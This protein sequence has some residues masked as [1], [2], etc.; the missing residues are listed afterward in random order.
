VDSGGV[1]RIGD[2]GCNA[3][4]R[5]ARPAAG[6][7]ALCR[8]SG[9]VYE[10]SLLQLGSEA[11]LGSVGLR[12][13]EYVDAAPTDEQSQRSSRIWATSCLAR[14]SNWQGIK[15]RHS[16]E[17]QSPNR[18]ADLMVPRP[19]RYH[20]IYSIGW[21]KSCSLCGSCGSSFGLTSGAI[22][23]SRIFRRLPVGGHDMVVSI[24]AS[25]GQ[26]GTTGRSHR[27]GMD[28]K[29]PSLRQASTCLFAGSKEMKL[30]KRHNQK[31]MANY[32]TFFVCSPRN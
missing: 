6:P 11:V 27:P 31:H 4:G 8:H 23:Q 16:E 19:H 32:S 21:M 25:A 10:R 14:M 15:W 13:E 20:R 24:T 26:R 1:R 28:Y 12:H 3:L 5:V 29:S 22:R 30:F 7:Q 17:D 18:R 9:S 2:P